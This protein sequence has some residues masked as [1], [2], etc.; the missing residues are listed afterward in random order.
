MCFVKNESYL[1]N[2]HESAPIISALPKLMQLLTYHHVAQQLHQTISIHLPILSQSTHI[3]KLREIEF[4]AGSEFEL[5]FYMMDNGKLAV[6]RF[7]CR[8]I[9][10]ILMNS[11]FVRGFL[12]IYPFLQAQIA[13]ALQ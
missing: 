12:Q 10:S 11:E 3:Q 5:T 9:A 6:I 8:D 2:P 1:H 13:H 4:C 7:Q